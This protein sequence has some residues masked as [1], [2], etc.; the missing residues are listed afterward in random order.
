[1]TQFEP[2][3]L[4]FDASVR[5][6]G[7]DQILATIGDVLEHLPIAVCIYD[8]SGKIVRFNQS[9]LE[10]WGRKPQP[11]ITH[12]AFVAGSKF[13]EP[14]GRML[15]YSEMPLAR[16]LKTGRA[17]REQE[18]TVERPDGS[19]I[20]TIVSINPLRDSDGNVIGAINC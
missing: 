4:E 8:R 1:M 17:V 9:A 19:R 18:Y 2:H 3:C 6:T 13:F 16:V 15:S 5:P 12:Q 11:G 7:P 10:I 14:N 20:T